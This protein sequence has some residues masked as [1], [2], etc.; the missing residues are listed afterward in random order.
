[1]EEVCGQRG[2]LHQKI[3]QVQAIELGNWKHFIRCSLYNHITKNSGPTWRDLS[4]TKGGAWAFPSISAQ[5]LVSTVQVSSAIAWSSL[6]QLCLL[7]S[8]IYLLTTLNT[9]HGQPQE[10]CC[11]CS[12]PSQQEKNIF[13]NADC[14]RRWLK[15]DRCLGSTADGLDDPPSPLQNSHP[16]PFLGGQKT[17]SFPLVC[18]GFALYFKGKAAISGN[19][20]TPWSSFWEA[21]RSSCSAVAAQG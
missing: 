4:V 18:G 10:N 9:R 2:R 17:C 12:T 7:C 5:L 20:L 13:A 21:T 16:F 3:N 6:P 15:R 8:L 14:H 1:M 11:I 19:S